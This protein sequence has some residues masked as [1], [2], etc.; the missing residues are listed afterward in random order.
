MT[1]SQV[2]LIAGSGIAAVG[3]GASVSRIPFKRIGLPASMAS[4]GFI[5]TLLTFIFAA[6]YSD[7]SLGSPMLA[8]GMLVI[9]PGG[10]L[11]ALTHVDLG[12]SQ[13]FATVWCASVNGVLFLMLGFGLRALTSLGR[14]LPT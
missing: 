1:W 11:A 9:A 12:R 13:V 8:L 14:K 7:H 3:I 4:A 5:A 2:A 10:L 6:V